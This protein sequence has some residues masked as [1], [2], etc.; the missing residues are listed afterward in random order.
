MTVRFPFKI[1]DFYILRHITVSDVTFPHLATTLT[2][3][4]TH[5]QATGM[6]FLRWAAR[7]KGSTFLYRSRILCNNHKISK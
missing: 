5:K 7:D 3:I 6:L 4:I 2:D 1:E